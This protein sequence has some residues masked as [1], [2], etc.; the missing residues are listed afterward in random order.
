MKIGSVLL[1][2]LCLLTSARAVPARQAPVHWVGS[3]AAAELAMEQK[4]SAAPVD[5]DD[6]TLRQVVHLSIGGPVLR[7]RISNA[8]GTGPLHLTAVHIARPLPDVPGAIIAAS[9]TALTFSGRA[10]VTIPAGAE[11]ISDPVA[12]PVSDLSDL[13]ITL[14]ADEAPSPETGHP[15]SRA[16]SFVTHG[17]A[18]SA[19]ELPGAEKREHWYVIAGVDVEASAASAAI[20]TF[21]DSITDSYQSTPDMNNRWPDDLARRLQA[22]PATRDIAVL[23]EGIDGNRVL[24]DGWGP[25]AL[26]RFDRDV[27]GPP[28][29]RYLIVLEGINDLGN[30]TREHKVPP[31]QHLALVERLIAAYKQIA[32]R[33]HAHG[34]K[35]YIGTVTPDMD[36]SYY[37]PD[38][39]NE[40][41]RE[42]L[43][44]WIRIQQDFDG[45]IDFDAAMRDPAHPDLMLPAYDSGDHLHP[46]PAGY[47]VMSDLVPLTL[48]GTPEKKINHR[49]V[50]AKR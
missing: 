34:I 28:G 37:P 1:A 25:N 42:E 36:N 11:Y 46:G 10:D 14:H 43:N 39:G 40:A 21:G 47:Q 5:L 6:A 2:A 19:A 16:T 50:G 41:D 3:W 27:L 12:F 26:S 22:S 18:V 4:N 7:L 9:D 24:L 29:V 13:V 31:S 45:V 8:F 49:K 32:E 17:D 35:A 33:A 38:A 15:G 20:V 48:F 30:L 44:A 23:N